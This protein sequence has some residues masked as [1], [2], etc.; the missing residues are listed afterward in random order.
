MKIVDGPVVVKSSVIV[1]ATVVVIRGVVVGLGVV[2]V[3][4]GYNSRTTVSFA[5][6]VAV[7]QCPSPSV[8]L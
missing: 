3:T 2:V 8:V 4:H 5:A 1:L 7:I 6:H